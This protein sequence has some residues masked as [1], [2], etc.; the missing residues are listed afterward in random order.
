MVLADVGDVLRVFFASEAFWGVVVSVV[1]FIW[2]LPRVRAW[3][4]SV[5]EGWWSQLFD[6]AL[7]RVNHTYLI[8][9][10]ELKHASA[11]GTITTD[12]ARTARE[13]TLQD[14]KTQLSAEAPSLLKHY[15]DDALRLAIELSVSWL[16]KQAVTPEAEDELG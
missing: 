15:G 5:R 11:D 13:N 4:D 9:V 3:R 10:Q 6:F 8:Y 16:K 7:Q 14:L 1:G 2:A 12:E